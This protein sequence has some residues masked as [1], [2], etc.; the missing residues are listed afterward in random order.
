MAEKW[1]LEYGLLD[2]E[3]VALILFIT[4]WIKNLKGLGSFEEIGKKQKE[5]N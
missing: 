5:M 3:K 1:C 4:N 2:K